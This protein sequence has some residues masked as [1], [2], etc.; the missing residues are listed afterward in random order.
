M[1]WYEGHVYA[2]GAAER[3]VC[4]MQQAFAMETNICTTKTLGLLPVFP[5]PG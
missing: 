2:P 1:G 3:R 4:L 5:H